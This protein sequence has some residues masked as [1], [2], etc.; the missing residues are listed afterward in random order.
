MN[1]KNSTTFYE[2]YI[3]F[4]SGDGR[5]PKCNVIFLCDIRGKRVSFAGLAH[6]SKVLFQRVTNQSQ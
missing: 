6:D 4:W 2:Y 3:L 1:V 5:V